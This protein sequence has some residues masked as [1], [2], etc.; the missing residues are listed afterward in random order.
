[1]RRRPINSFILI[2]SGTVAKRYG[3][4]TAIRA[5]PNLS[6]LLNNF[7]FIILGEGENKKEFENLAQQIGVK[8]YVEFRPPIPIDDVPGILSQA[9]AGISPHVNDINFRWSFPQKVYEY[10]YMGLPVV[11][12]RTYVL[13]HYFGDSIY[14]STSGDP[15]SI[16]D[17]VLSIY[18]DW[19]GVLQKM[20]S[21]NKLIN[22][23]N[24]MNEKKKLAS[25]V[26]NMTQR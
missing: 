8:D 23:L 21:A 13:E 2:Y 1:M 4:D 7:K 26:V 19:E 11:S 3:I 6:K 15:D 17:A 18:F 14:Y 24:W 25:L 9:D 10:L 5:V 12:T 22:K 16:V 20:E